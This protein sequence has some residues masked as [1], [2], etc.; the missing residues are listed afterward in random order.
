MSSLPVFLPSTPKPDEPDRGKKPRRKTRRGARSGALAGGGPHQTRITTI[1]F[2]ETHADGAI[3]DYQV[4]LPTSCDQGRSY[5][6]SRISL[7]V[8]GTCPDRAAI[9]LD[10]QLII[11]RVQTTTTSSGIQNLLE[12]IGVSPPK[13][14]SIVGG[15]FSMR[16]P[17]NTDWSQIQTD[18]GHPETVA[19]LRILNVTG[20]SVEVTIVGTI[21]WWERLN[22][23]LR[24][25]ALVSHRC[26][27]SSR[28]RIR[29]SE[30][31]VDQACPSC[32]DLRSSICKC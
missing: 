5:K 17:P 4:D 6:C 7:H 21:H 18:A 8:I 9:A 30:E 25:D 19:T 24:P 3:V 16:Y 13:L 26:V 12:E 32:G 1:R 2:N 10:C 23:T 20:A 28:Y 22:D 29:K 27:S 14:V 11:N 31:M 15:R